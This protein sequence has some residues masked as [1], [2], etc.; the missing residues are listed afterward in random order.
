MKKAIFVYNLITENKCRCENVARWCLRVKLLGFIGQR[1][2]EIFPLLCL[3]IERNERASTKRNFNR[4]I[5]N[6]KSIAAGS[7]RTSKKW[8]N[9][10]YENIRARFMKVQKALP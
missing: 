8:I 7:E 3:G 1:L 10:V 6:K 4:K 9:E 2:M 5:E